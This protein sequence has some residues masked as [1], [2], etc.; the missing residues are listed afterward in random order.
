MKTR[1]CYI[2]VHPRMSTHQCP[3]LVY[4]GRTQ[5]QLIRLC[6][7]QKY[8]L[9][10]VDGSQRIPEPHAH[11]RRSFYTACT[12]SIDYYDYPR[13]IM[14]FVSKAQA[15]SHVLAMSRQCAIFCVMPPPRRKPKHQTWHGSFTGRPFQQAVCVRGCC[16]CHATHQ[17]PH[18]S[19]LHR[20]SQCVS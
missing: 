3:A 1:V 4:R 10:V 2:V 5:P 16:M 12:T 11:R 18:Q 14:R 6:T 13:P 15:P 20:P 7:F 19:T 17:H 9:L 8:L